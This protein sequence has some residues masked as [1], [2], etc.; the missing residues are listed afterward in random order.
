MLHGAIRRLVAALIS[1]PQRAKTAGGISSFRRICRSMNISGPVWAGS[2]ATTSANA[3]VAAIGSS[4]GVLFLIL[5]ASM[6][7][8][9]LET[10][11]ARIGPQVGPPIKVASE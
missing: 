2:C 3:F 11:P 5:L 7:K 4:L 9:P 10:G 8:S 1:I 6:L